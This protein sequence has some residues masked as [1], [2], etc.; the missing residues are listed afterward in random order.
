MS[1]ICIKMLVFVITF[2]MLLLIIEARFHN[3]HHKKHKHA[4][5]ISQISLPPASAPGP[6]PTDSPAVECPYNNSKGVFDVRAFG[7][8]GDGVTDDT[9]AVKT[10]WDA[11][12]HTESG[13]LLVP[14]GYSF[15]IQ[16]TIFLGPCQGGLIFQ[17]FI[18]LFDMSTYFL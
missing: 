5:P 10:A 3:H 7:A 17:V 6:S 13:V 9:V 14:N 4:H 15:M 16:S 1:S 11:A 12:C 8:V 18:C 2:D